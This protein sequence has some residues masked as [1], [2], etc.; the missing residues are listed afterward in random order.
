[1]NRIT[2]FILTIVLLV[3]C[4]PNDDKKTVTPLFPLQTGNTWTFIDSVFSSSG[5]RTD[6]TNLTIGEYVEIAGYKG[7]TLPLGQN[8]FHIKFL[9]QNDENGNFINIGGYSDV[10]TLLVSSVEFK[11]NAVKGES[12]IYKNVSVTPDDGYF[13]S[14]DLVMTCLAT[15][16]IIKTPKGNIVCTSFSYSPN[17]GEDI[18]INYI[19]EGVGIIKTEHYELNKLY[20]TRTIIDY[21]LK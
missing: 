19:S 13:E 1:M 12:W 14:R 5:L 10:D 21:D 18:F 8:S 20:N 15:D 6:T 4:E 3:S 7:Y 16:T 2:L 9:A 11:K 17:S